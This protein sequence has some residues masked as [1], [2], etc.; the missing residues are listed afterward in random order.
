MTYD[1]PKDF[2]IYKKLKPEQI[3]QHLDKYAVFKWDEERLETWEETVTRAV[4]ILRSLSKNGLSDYDYQEMFTLIYKHEVMPSMRLLSM[5][6]AAV[7]RCNTVLYNCYAGVC[8]SLHSISEALYLSSS[9]VGVAWSVEKQHVSKIPKIKKQTGLMFYDVVEDSQ[10]GWARSTYK[11]LDTLQKGNDLTV[12]YSRIRPAGMPLKTK[13]GYS[14][15]PEVLVRTHAFIR[16]IMLGAQGRKLKPIEMHD[17][18]CVALESGISGG[19]RRSAGAALFDKDD[20]E[21]RTCK[22]DGFWSN[23]DHKYRANANNSAVIDG[24]LTLDELVKETSQMFST[25]SGEPGLFKRD[26]ALR[27]DR[28]FIHYENI[29]SNPCFAAGTMVKTRNGDYP[30]ESLV[31]KTVEVWNGIQWVFVDNFRVTG[32]NQEVYKVILH[33][34]SEIIATP[35]HTFI[36]DDGTRKQLHELSVGDKLMISES[37]DTHGNK[38]I[39]GAYLKGFLLGDGTNCK[40]SLKL[41]LYE[42]KYMCEWRLIESANQIKHSE[43][44]YLGHAIDEVRFNN[45]YKVKT[46]EFKSMTGLTQR[47]HELLRYVQRDNGL[48]QELFEADYDSKCEFLAGLFDADGT[49][50]DT[51]NGFLYQFISIHQELIKDVQLLLKSI[52]VDSKLSVMK[53]SGS[54]DFGDGYGVYATQTSYRLTLNQVAAI[55]F[56][57]QVKFSRLVSFAD[58]TVVYNLKPKWNRIVSIE[59]Y[60]IADEVYCCTVPNTHQFSLSCGIDVGNCFEVLLQAI[61]VDSEIFPGGGGQFCNLSSVIVRKSDTP[62]TLRHKTKYGTLI[63]DIQSLATHFQ[64]LRPATKQICDR[65]RLL[66]VNLLG[67]ALYPKKF[68]DDLLMNLRD[69]T[70]ETDLGFSEKFG[71]PQSASV[72]TLKPSGNSSVFNATSPGVN[73][74]HSQYQIRNVTVNKLSTMYRFLA[75]AGVPHADYPGRPYAAMFSFPVHY[76][77]DAITLDNCDAIQ[78]LENWKKF[79]VNWA[80]HNVSC[81]ITYEPHEIESIQQWLFL[82]QDIIGGLAFFPK[83]DSSYALLPI[84]TVTKEQYDEFM[85]TYPKIDWHLYQKYEKGIDERVQVAECA[86]GACAV[87]W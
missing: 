72:T 2:D 82:N 31:G 1:L 53:T 68:T 65:D 21:M 49:A 25:G 86:G 28:D 71:V 77:N 62:E 81:S 78:Q 36:L 76:G 14:S 34:G 8:D 74:L 83:Y 40:N 38:G 22:Y 12:D 33:D 66:G 58:K 69:Y 67:Y 13:G 29:C 5:P 45:A 85:K 51:R 59:P 70:I 26:N 87:Q 44:N 3:F 35:Y 61:P 57:Q 37:D 73:P 32:T 24:G 84:V 11:L 7:K 56:A 23:E 10:E 48:P 50:S 27:H 54:V 79:M 19:V 60:G 80:T 43:Y 75:D 41:S 42:P 4:D 52:G 30:I 15:G 16:K 47:K 9:G 55:K 46:T 63:G 17:M 64:F 39:N 6:Q 18:M 20:Q